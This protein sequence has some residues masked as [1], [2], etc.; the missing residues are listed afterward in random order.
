VLPIFDIL[1]ELGKIEERSIYNTFNMGI[2]MVM[3]VSADIA[4]DVVKYL[5]STGEK[6][7]IIGS[8][9]EGEAGVDIC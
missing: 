4:E 3:A 5:D 1:Q 6:A 9:A 8:I 2:G 7:Y